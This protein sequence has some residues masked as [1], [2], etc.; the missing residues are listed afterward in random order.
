MND[1]QTPKTEQQILLEQLQEQNQLLKKIA[2][3]Q[4]K[5]YRKTLRSDMWGIVKHVLYIGAGVYFLWKAQ[6]FFTGLFSSITPDFSGLADG[7]GASANGAGDSI[8]NLLKE[9]GF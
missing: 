5:M 9:I 6:M 2:D 7:L 1:M 4:Q 8:Q 3:Y